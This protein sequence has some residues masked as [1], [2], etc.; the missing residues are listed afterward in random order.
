[1]A[2]D[3]SAIQHAYEAIADAYDATFADELEANEFDRAIVDSAIATHAGQGEEHIERP[4]GDGSG[5]VIVTYYEADELI[6]LAEG[7]GLAP[8]EL[9]ER[10]P[11]GHERQVRKLFLT[12]TAV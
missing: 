8:V 5:T 4:R 6:G 2:F 11:L 9:R 10:Q 7:H 3:P 12:T 1:M